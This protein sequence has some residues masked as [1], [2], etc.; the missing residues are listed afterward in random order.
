[1][2]TNPEPT[3]HPGPT[4]PPSSSHHP[5]WSLCKAGAARNSLILVF[6]SLSS[7]FLQ[8][9]SLQ[10]LVTILNV[11]DNSPVFAQTNLTVVLPEVSVVRERGGC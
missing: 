3:P 5:L 10:V 1:M 4:Q 8:G 9:D 11:N 7:P 2:G 6:D